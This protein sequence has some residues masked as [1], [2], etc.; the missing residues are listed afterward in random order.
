M[1]GEARSRPISVKG[2]T[3]FSV[4]PEGVKFGKHV[5]ETILGVVNNSMTKVREGLAKW[6][7]EREQSQGGSSLGLTPPVG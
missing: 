5:L 1:I 7:R 3:T 6:K 2:P 4:L